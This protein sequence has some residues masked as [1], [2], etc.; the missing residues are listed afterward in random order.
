MKG[1]VASESAAAAV[2]TVALNV[3][4][5]YLKCVRQSLLIF[6]FILLL[7]FS[8]RRGLHALMLKEHISFL[9]LSTAAALYSV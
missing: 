4:N 8:S 1:K 9:I 5:A 2:H 3:L 6:R 7:K